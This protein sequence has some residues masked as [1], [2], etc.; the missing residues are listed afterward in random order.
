MK[1][2]ISIATAALLVGVGIGFLLSREV[3]ER[4]DRGAAMAGVLVSLDKNAA[5]IDRARG[6]C[7]AIGSGPDY[8]PALVELAKFL[9]ARSDANNAAEQLIASAVEL[10]RRGAQPPYDRMSVSERQAEIQRII[11]VTAGR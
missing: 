2:H 7:T 4:A 1:H 3:Q 10:V 5:P 9:R 11:E 6:V 8:V